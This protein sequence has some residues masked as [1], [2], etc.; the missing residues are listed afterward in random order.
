SIPTRELAERAKAI[1]KRE[2]GV[3]I[4]RTR[5][6]QVATERARK[7]MPLGVPSSFQAY[8]PHPIV[9]RR[10]RDSWMED[11]DGNRYTDFDMGFGA[12]FSG[13]C[14][15]AVRS[16]VERQ[17]D[18]G[19]LFVTPCELNAEVAE[20]LG[21]RYGLPMWRFT[22]SGTEATM[23][24]IRVARGVTGR[25]KIVKVEGGYHGHHDEVM[26]S[27]KPPVS[28]AGPADAPRAIPATAGITRAVLGDTIVVPYNNLEALERALKGGDVACFIVEPVMEN[29]GICKP[30]PGY[31]EG[32]RALT[33][34]YGTMLI[35]DEV[36]TG[37]TAGWSGATGVLGVQP[38]LVSLAKCIGGGLPLGAFG[39]TRECM[40]QITNGKVLH[41]GT[42][43]GNPLCMAAAKAVLAEVCTPEATQAT[44][45]RNRLLLDACD[46]IIADAGLPA[47]TVQFG[48]K[49]CVTWTPEPI[50]NYRDYKATDFDLAFAQW[51]HGI[52]R[53]ILLPPGLDEQWLISVL[54][55]DA[56]ALRYADVFGEF[57]AELTA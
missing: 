22:N 9:V 25:E 11:V 30:L 14:H 52:N 21:E 43:N 13:H 10:A 36:K 35:F 1:T 38:D 56:D 37:I 44:I 5:G 53:G 55:T 57:V 33:R 18:D 32:V 2:L 20:L 12:L 41:L 29:I 28:E 3:Y 50:Q 23:D 34:K 4:D 54:H 15:P 7:V 49:G 47:H 24:A 8:D 46:R 40:D 26:I 51:M 6:S 27:M 42:Y 39:G 48:A 17:L 19:T 45:A 31:L 16:A